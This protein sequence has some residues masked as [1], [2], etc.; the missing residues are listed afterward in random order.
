MTVPLPPMLNEMAGVSSSSQFVA[1]YYSGSKATWNDGRSSATFPFYTV[2]QPYTEHLAIAVDL[3]DYNLGSDDCL[4]THALVCDRSGEKVY[5]APFAEAMNFLERQHPPRQEITQ[6]QWEEIKAQ[7][8]DWS[9]LSM[10]E[11]QALG[12][13]EMFAA[14]PKYKEKTIELIRWLDGYINESLLRRYLVAATAGDKRAAWG[15]EMF[16]RR[17]QQ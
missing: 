4:A 2:W 12:M 11:M 10:E 1:L 9:P 7:L 14:N 17:C 13:F 3:F 6:Q 15:L 16:K 8:E 5:V